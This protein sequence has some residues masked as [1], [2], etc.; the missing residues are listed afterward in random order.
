MATTSSITGTDAKT[1]AQTYLAEPGTSQISSAQWLDI[2]NQAQR[3]V[4]ELIIAVNPDQFSG[5][6]TITW[7]ANTDALTLTG[8]SYVNDDIYR[9]VGVG[10][11]NSASYVTGS[12]TF[13]RLKPI[14]HSDLM[15][16]ME[17]YGP[18]GEPLVY[19]TTGN[20]TML[21]LY[22]APFPTS[23]SLI[24]I[25]Y[26][27]YIPDLSTLSGNINVP[28]EYQDAV[29]RRAASIANARTRSPNP[30][31]EQLWNDAKERIEKTA[32]PK[33]DDEPWTVRVVSYGYDP[34]EPYW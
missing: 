27:E 5:T 20:T 31:V 2:I 21:K 33:V 17:Q 11:C 4:F 9:I 34:S 18:T 22:L 13:K 25:S 8:S 3:E 23:A 6:T 12:S 19:T 26:V 32:G 16:Y 10:L 24:A 29:A 15:R 7:P 28:L 14:R 1:R 30:L